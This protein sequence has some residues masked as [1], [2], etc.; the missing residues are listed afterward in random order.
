ML[1]EDTE[2]MYSLSA[3]IISPSTAALTSYGPKAANPSPPGFSIALFHSPYLQQLG[4]SRMWICICEQLPTVFPHT[5]CCLFSYTV[6]L[7]PGFRINA[8]NETWFHCQPETPAIF[9]KRWWFWSQ[10]NWKPRSLILIW[11]WFQGIVW[12]PNS[13]STNSKAKRE[14][15]LLDPWL[16]EISKFYSRT[17][18]FFCLWKSHSLSTHLI[19]P[20]QVTVPIM[21]L[22]PIHETL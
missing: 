14:K 13:Q 16:T 8:D 20:Y 5:L 2:S 9:T 18:T 12:T 17:R 19:I 11:L 15:A 7:M 6:L 22:V 10:T 21:L 3:F 4:E 1:W